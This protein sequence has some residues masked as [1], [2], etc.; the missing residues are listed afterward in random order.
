[1]GDKK[2]GVVR[3]ILQGICERGRE[4][5]GRMGDKKG[6][7]IWGILQGICEREREKAGW[8]IRREALSGGYCRGYA[9]G[10]TG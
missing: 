4:R 10:R 1:M 2:G 8:K 6:G 5:G 7:V 9:R 3:G